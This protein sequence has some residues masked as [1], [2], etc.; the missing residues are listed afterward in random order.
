VQALR[1]CDEYAQRDGRSPIVVGTTIDPEDGSPTYGGRLQS[2]MLRPLWYDLVMPSDA[3]QRCDT[4]NGNFVLVPREVFDSVGNL[5]PVFVHG[6]ADYD[7]GLR[8]R[9]AG[10][11]ILVMP[12]VAGTCRRN[13]IRGTEP[14]AQASIV[15][16]LKA[17]VSPKRFPPYP[18]LVYT[19]RH[20]GP[21]WVIHWVRPY[22]KAL[23]G[24]GDGRTRGLR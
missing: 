2:G 1:T 24:H 6:M 9:E 10:F 7:Y 11:A 16:R 13:P 4:M 21:A 12:G 18:W 8:A 15:D 19:F 20:A 14:G 23:V 5:D 3:V 22:W 17:V